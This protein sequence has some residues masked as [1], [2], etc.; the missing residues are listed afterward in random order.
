MISYDYC[1][2]VAVMVRSVEVWVFD[3]VAFEAIVNRIDL[4]R[5]EI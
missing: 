2:G 1:C 3:L 5:E 4:F